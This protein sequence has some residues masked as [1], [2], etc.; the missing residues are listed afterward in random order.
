MRLWRVGQS[1]VGTHRSAKS[2]RPEIPSIEYSFFRAPSA[3][4]RRVHEI[5]SNGTRRESF[6]ESGRTL[7]EHQA[8]VGSVAA[9][10]KHFAGIPSPLVSWIRGGILSGGLAQS[11]SRGCLAPSPHTT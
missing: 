4:A 9:S 10:L 5:L 2:R 8:T 7:L 1:S 6:T 3:T 11:G